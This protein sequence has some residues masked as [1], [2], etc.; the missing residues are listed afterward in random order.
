MKANSTLVLLLSVCA[1]L[2]AVQVVSGGNK[3]RPLKGSKGGL[4]GVL[5]QGRP[6]PLNV[7]PFS[8]A[9]KGG[10]SGSESLDDTVLQMLRDDHNPADFRGKSAAQKKEAFSKLYN[11]MIVETCKALQLMC[12]N[13]AD[14]LRAWFGD[15]GVQQSKESLESC[16]VLV[17]PAKQAEIGEKFLNT[18]VNKL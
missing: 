15:A 16:K 12:D 6:T 2:C 9:N 4:K 10:L 18:V 11:H 17:T 1:I 8:N 14:L 13:H 7:G 5:M 3:N